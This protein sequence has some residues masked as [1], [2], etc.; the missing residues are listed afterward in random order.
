M[1]C[2]VNNVTHLKTV[3][4]KDLW[5]QLKSRKS[6]CK[7]VILIQAVKV[8]TR[9]NWNELQKKCSNIYRQVH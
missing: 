9:S 4:E 2:S 5:K 7:H 6:H 8:E 1:K 3:D